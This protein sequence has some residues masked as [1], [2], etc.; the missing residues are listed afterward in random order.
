MMMIPSVA[1]TLVVA[2]LVYH[3]R[4]PRNEV[5]TE[6]NASLSTG[7]ASLD[8]SPAP[9]V[10]ASYDLSAHQT[11]SRVVLLVRENYVEPERINSYEMFLA[12]LDYIQRSI[13]EVMVDDSQAPERIKVSVGGAEQTFELGG[14]DQLWEVTMALRDI[15]RFLQTQLSNP[16]QRREV[17][18]A[19]INGMLSTLDP[20]TVLLKPE[21]FDEMKLSTKGE[22]GGLGIVISIRE[23]ALTIISPIEGTPASRAGIK[24]KDKIVKIGEESTVNMNLEEAVQRLR[25]RPGTKVNLWVLRKGWTEAKRFILTRAIIKIESVTSE[26]LPDSIGYVKIKSFQ[27]NTYD[28]LHEALESLRRKN[29]GELKGLVLDLR[30]NPGGLLDQAILVSDRFIDH[31][32]I[33]ITVG[34]G[35]RKREEKLAHSAGTESNYPMAVLVNGGSASASEIVS[36]ALK[37]HNRAIIIGQQTFGKGSVQVLYDFKDKSA[38]KL[39]IAQYLTPGDISIQS[40]GIAPDVEIAPATI[41]KGSVHLF[42]DDDSP[43]EKDLEKH[44]ARHEGQ[45]VADASGPAAR[46]V[47][48][49]ADP[50]LDPKAPADDETEPP[51]E[52]FQYD[53]ETHLAHD[54]IASASGSDRKAILEGA[55]ALFK[56]RS[57]EEEGHIE[58]RFREIGIDWSKGTPQ[59]VVV[60]AA[61]A[62]QAEL[63]VANKT[64]TPIHA[65]ETVTLTATVKNGSDQPLSRV[66]GVTA[67]DNQLFKNLEFV[68]GKV[69]PRETK[70]WSIDI[71]LPEDLTPRADTVTLKVS[72][73]GTKLAASAAPVLVNIDEVP[74]P[75]FAFTW[76]LGDASGDG[77][78][79]PGEKVNLGIEVSDIGAGDAKEAVVSL[80]NLSG[81]A[82]FL[83]RG[84]EKLGVIKSGTSHATALK[85]AVRDGAEVDKVEVRVSIWDSVLGAPLV[86]TLRLPVARERR[87]QAEAKVL[88]VTADGEV[89]VFG[90][91][92]AQASILGYVKAGALLRSDARVDNDW[93]RVELSPEQ[94]GFVREA[95]VK[96]VKSALKLTARQ[97]I[98][99][100][101]GHAAPRIELEP[102][103]LVTSD[104]VYHVRGAI[105]DDHALTDLFVFVDDK[106]VFYRSLQQLKV[107]AD[108]LLRVPLDVAL[109]LKDGA[110]TVTVVARENQDVLVR[111]TIGVF[112][113]PADAIAGYGRGPLTPAAQ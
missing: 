54:V 55:A 108:G 39:T 73:E 97:V 64:K 63:Q 35:N 87:L 95:D 99:R 3:V 58:Q 75:R 91:A 103:A 31:G 85:F 104:K 51:P 62:V 71:K 81:D 22:F 106:K 88:K 47:H 49:G 7:G 105:V 109:P 107:G 72:E 18:Y 45:A 46:L 6:L 9:S 80:K 52:R 112:R 86:E 60:A 111:K 110:N 42:V 37:N 89:P 98:R 93:R 15:F 66:Y 12:A 101:S 34:E 14:L 25:G 44:L 40:V 77:S 2:G 59:E 53:F 82:L 65:G 76:W 41:S 27:N 102:A 5:V 21:S 30:N 90:A 100:A 92:L 113:A 11:L 83:E 4:A 10:A 56:S 96:P 36:G 19:A 74:K 68:F 20:H 43:H 48:L 26:L 79:Q 33:V 70:S 28:D 29:K 16:E 67:S 57:S 94:N 61:G 50:D 69:G 24:T 8:D 13:P 23:G 38:L 17:E 1:A 78:L 32:P 84:R